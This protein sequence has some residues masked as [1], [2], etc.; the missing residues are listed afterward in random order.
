M[1]DAH[2]SSRAGIPSRLV[3]LLLAVSCSSVLA[4]R[5][6]SGGELSCSDTRGVRQSVRLGDGDSA[7]L[8]LLVGACGVHSP[9]SFVL[10]AGC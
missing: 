2:P 10:L 3:L 6:D 1:E 9:F 8:A 4:E 7:T 5:K